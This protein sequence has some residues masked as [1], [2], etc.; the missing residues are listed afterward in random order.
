MAPP[1]PGDGAWRTHFV[2]LQRDA[3]VADIHR[4]VGAG[5]R[6]PEH[7]KRYTTIGTGADQGRTSGVG[8]LSGSWLSCWASP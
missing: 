6:S 1:D 5:M 2:D 4:A 8:T 7:V 3:T